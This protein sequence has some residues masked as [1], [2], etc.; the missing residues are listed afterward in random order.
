MP[1][2]G[3]RQFLLKVLQIGYTFTPADGPTCS[4]PDENALNTDPAAVRHCISAQ[5]V[6]ELLFICAPATFSCVMA[7]HANS[8]SLL[9]RSYRSAPEVATG[10]SQARGGDRTG[11]LVTG[12]HFRQKPVR[13]F[14]RVYS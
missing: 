10:M 4:A 13:Y 1:R 3:I 14:R 12:S 11:G 5:R 6:S 2:F 7:A 9:P 8:L